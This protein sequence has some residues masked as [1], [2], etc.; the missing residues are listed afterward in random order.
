MAV[1]S[2]K[3]IGEANLGKAL[4]FKHGQIVRFMKEN[5]YKIK[6]MISKARKRIPTEENMLAA[7]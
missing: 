7:L 5:G 2:T 1:S 3:V 6:D 4:V